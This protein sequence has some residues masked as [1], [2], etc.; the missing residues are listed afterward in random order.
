V[1]AAGDNREQRLENRDQKLKNREQKLEDTFGRM[2]ERLIE[3][4]NRVNEARMEAI[5]RRINEL[6]EDA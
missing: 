5:D 1:V 4:T 2:S 3:H 6:E